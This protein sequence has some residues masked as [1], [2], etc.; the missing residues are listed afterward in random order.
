MYRQSAKT[1]SWTKAQEAA[2]KIELKFE[3]STLL[4]RPVQGEP[5]T[6]QKAIALFLADKAAQDL[7]PATLAKLRMI[8][9]KQMLSWC[10]ENGI[11]F[12]QTPVVT[13]L[14]VDKSED[15]VKD[16]SVLSGVCDTAC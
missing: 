6:T 2:R 9:E 5:V 3:K 1:R 10:A 8:F 4:S 12:L 7:K 14:A 13:S 16:K 11:H 15:C